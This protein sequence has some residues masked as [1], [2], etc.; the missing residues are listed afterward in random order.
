MPRPLLEIDHLT[1]EFTAG[2]GI[3]DICLR[4]FPG[5]FI[6]LAGPNGSGKTTLIRHL[7][8]LVRPSSGE[9]RLHGRP[10]TSDIVFARKTIGMVFQD[11]DTQIV[12]DTVFDEVAFGPENLKIPRP[13][14]R[15]KV[16]QTLARMDLSH[17]ADRNP[18]TLSGGEKRRLTIAGI[19][20]MD[21]EIIV[22][23]EPFANLDYPSS[24]ALVGII[25][26]LNQEGQT[27]IMATHE[28]EDVITCATRIIIMDSKGRLSRDGRPE[29]LL[30]H[31]AACG[32]KEPCF[33][34]M[35]YKK[36]PWQT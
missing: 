36:P 25:S 30:G 4:V 19:L 11:A 31:L 24:K 33:S 29:D 27:I 16:T 22:L 35:G 13:L 10:V 3:Y 23:D 28:V 34:R 20:V 26:E 18:A 15:E 5:E 14:I 17:L 8:A 2:S 12:G 21:P 1:H 7:N 9:V 6:L 32:V